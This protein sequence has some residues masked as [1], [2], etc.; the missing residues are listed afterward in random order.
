MVKLLFFPFALILAFASAQADDKFNISDANNPV[1]FTVEAPSHFILDPSHTFLASWTSDINNEIII[2]GFENRQ[3]LFEYIYNS[4][5]SNA[6]NIIEIHRTYTGVEIN[7]GDKRYTVEW[8]YALRIRI[9]STKKTYWRFC[10]NIYECDLPAPVYPAAE[11]SVVSTTTQG[12]IVS[13]TVPTRCTRN[14]ALN[15]TSIVLLSICCVSV[16]IVIGM[17]VYIIRGRRAS[18]NEP[19]SNMNTEAIY[20]DVQL[21]G[22]DSRAQQNHEIENV[23][24]GVVIL[25]QA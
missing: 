4:S 8:R 1:N 22:N 3:R 23:L 7:P 20:D 25:R 12:S 2:E 5:E 19:G 6:W 15:F 17:A 24:Y 10:A 21:P 13:S 9:T 14:S 18:L 11:F 16:A